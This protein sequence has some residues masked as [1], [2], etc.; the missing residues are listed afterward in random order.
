MIIILLS[1]SLAAGSLL[2]SLSTNR[3]LALSLIPVLYQEVTSWSMEGI[4]E[5]I[6]DKRFPANPYPSQ[7]LHKPPLDNFSNE[8]RNNPNF[9]ASKRPTFVAFLRNNKF[10]HKIRSILDQF[11]AVA[12]A[13]KFRRLLLVTTVLTLSALF[14][15]IRIIGPFVMEETAVWNSLNVNTT[16]STNGVFGTN[17][18]PHFPNMIHLQ[19]LDPAL[20]PGSSKGTHHKDDEKKKRL[21]FIGDIH[22]CKDE[23]EDLLKEVHFN[24]VTDHLIA[25]GDIVMKGPDTPG[26]IDLLR[27]YN[28]SC[29]RG[30]H[31][32]RLLLVAE[33]LKSNSLRSNKIAG[34][35]VD[36]GHET[37]SFKA[38]SQE[39]KLARSLSADQL[40][41]LKAF[42]VILRVGELKA[43]GGEAIVVHAG[44]VP[45]LPLEEQ[46]PASVMNM[47]VVDLSTHVPSKSHKKEG[48]I[49]WYTLWKKH[50]QLAPAQ[51]HLAQLRDSGKWKSA[52]KPTTVIYGHDAKKGL[53]IK[54]FTKGLDSGCVAGGRLTALVVD[55]KGK[56]TVF[57]VSC[58]DHR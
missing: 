28:A 40:A 42:P 34:N 58:R 44:L 37:E 49:P 26:V 16:T 19:D 31:E 36:L 25:T 35:G 51:Q 11:L 3:W 53:Q 4:T 48:S 32:D 29:V 18:R 52:G 6:P 22:G 54:K 30:N 39:R 8:R 1:H 55:D 13:P 27:G 23:L 2:P 7:R 47:R 12:K 15:L 45:G 9:A 21:V 17:I 14:L 20:L 46:D 56:E 38:D 41:Y 33:D 24:P 50:Q 10:L 43:F 57:Q 5:K